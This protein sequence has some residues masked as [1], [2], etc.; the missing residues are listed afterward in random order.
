MLQILLET[1]SNPLQPIITLVG[2][3]I[4]MLWLFLRQGKKDEKE[5]SNSEENKNKMQ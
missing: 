2:F 5:D 4:A 1:Q 3:A